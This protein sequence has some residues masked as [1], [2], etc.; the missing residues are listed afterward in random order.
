MVLYTW[1][2]ILHAKEPIIYPTSPGLCN[3]IKG[4]DTK[5]LKS[6]ASRWSAFLNSIHSAVIRN[7]TRVKT[8]QR[9]KWH[10]FIFV[11]KQPRLTKLKCNDQ[12]AWQ[13]ITWHACVSIIIRHPHY[14]FPLPAC[15]RSGL[16]TFINPWFPF[17]Y[18]WNIIRCSGCVPHE[19]QAVK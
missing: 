7:V 4:I 18:K 15:L 16:K 11:M 17:W 9:C 5:P 10:G 8:L 14:R 12:T 3:D 19:Y 1:A 13:L 2:P 6:I